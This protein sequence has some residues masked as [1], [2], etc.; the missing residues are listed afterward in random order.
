MTGKKIVVAYW[1][2]RIFATPDYIPSPWMFLYIYR[3]Q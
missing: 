1:H 3:E 2:P